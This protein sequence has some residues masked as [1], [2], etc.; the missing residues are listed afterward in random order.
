MKN[1]LKRLVLSNSILKKLYFGALVVM[2]RAYCYKNTQPVLFE[3][4]GMVSV[5]KPSWMDSENNYS[6]TFL[7]VNSKIIKLVEQ[8][9]INLSQFDRKAVSVELK[10]LQWRHYI[11]YSSILLAGNS[12]T[13]D[14]FIAIELGVCDGLT[15]AYAIEAMTDHIGKEAKIYLI[16]AWEAMRESELLKEEKGAVGAYSYLSLSNTINNLSNFVFNSVY[17]KGYVPEILADAEI[18]AYLDWLHIDLNASQPTV[19][20][21]DFFWERIRAGGIILL[22]DYGFIGYDETRKAVDKWVNKSNAF[23]LAIPT[24]QA[25]IFKN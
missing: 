14:D 10:Q 20:A 23:L 17:I 4:W 13:Y 9:K 21:I 11:V 12:R 19:A 1:Y 22:D 5:N 3:G 18:P 24:G 25:I 6:K 15:A 16:D 2:G 8:D 7:E